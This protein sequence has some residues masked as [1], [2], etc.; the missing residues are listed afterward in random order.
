MKQKER[1]LEERLE[2]E[3]QQSLQNDGYD[4]IDDEKEIHFDNS[5][6]AV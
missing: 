2:R 3:F 4:L 5:Y 1:L 6:V